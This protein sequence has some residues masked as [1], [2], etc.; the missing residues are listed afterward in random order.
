MVIT[1]NRTNVGLNWTFVSAMTRIIMILI[2]FHFTVNHVIMDISL[3]IFY[4]E[5]FVA[6]KHLAPDSEGDN[7]ALSTN[8]WQERFLVGQF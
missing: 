6:K 8:I 3:N 5:I 1:R 2:E 7:E 4:P